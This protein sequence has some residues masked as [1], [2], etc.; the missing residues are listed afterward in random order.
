M[1]FVK[2]FNKPSEAI[3]LVAVSK[4]QSFEKIKEAYNLGIRDFGESYAQE[5]KN[6]LAQARLRNFT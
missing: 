1:I 5:F 3:K 2:Q 6:K 4:G